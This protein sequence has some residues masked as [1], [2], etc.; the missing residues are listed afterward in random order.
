M[1][2]RTA[3]VATR[4]VPVV[5]IRRDRETE[6]G[7]R[8]GGVLRQKGALQGNAGF[9]SAAQM[10]GMPQQQHQSFGFRAQ[11]AS[12]IPQAVGSAQQPGLQAAFNSALQPSA[13]KQPRQVASG[14]PGQAGASQ[15]GFCSAE[16]AQQGAAGSSVAQ[17]GRAPGQPLQNAPAL[18]ASLQQLR[19]LVPAGQQQWAQSQGHQIA[20]QATPGMAEPQGASQSSQQQHFGGPT[21]GRQQTGNG[22]SSSAWQPHQATAYLQ[23]D[24]RMSQVCERDVLFLVSR[25]RLVALAE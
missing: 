14:F 6:A 4:R 15:S 12:A 8:L 22:D 16:F 24:S 21:A 17:Y 18:Q 2:L 19:H 20:G 1:R 7:L 9:S 3:L 23:A 11:P 25:E 13:S 10:Q 5:G